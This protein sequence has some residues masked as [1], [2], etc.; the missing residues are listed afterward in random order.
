ML[1]YFVR[2]GQ[3]DANL[4]QRL[5]GSGL[6]HP[7][8]STGHAQAQALA[9]QIRQHIQHPLHRLI[10]SNMTRARETASHL[11]TSLGLP[12]ELAADFR[13]WNLG[14][15]EGQP[16][17]QFAHLLLGDGE[18]KQGET[19]ALFYARIEK[20]WRSIHHEEKPYLVV[21]HG[22]VW[23]ALQDLLKIPR[24]KI[25]NCQVAKIEKG[26]QGWSARLL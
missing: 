21:S 4:S 14:E 11:S 20:V 24:F 6:D 7:L 25:E 17:S 8:N 26:T 3:T 19:R 23:L 16:Y 15:W 22:A 12:I 1:F 10:A 5:A 18:P 2:H 9:A 13:E